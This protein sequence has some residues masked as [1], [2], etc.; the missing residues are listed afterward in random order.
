MSEK[1]DS[2]QIQFPTIHLLVSWTDNPVDDDSWDTSHTLPS[3]GFTDENAITFADDMGVD[4]CCALWLYEGPP[5][6]VGVHERILFNPF[7]SQYVR[8]VRDAKVIPDGPCEMQKM[9]L[10]SEAFARGG[11]T[12]YNDQRDILKNG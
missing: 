5:Y 10:L 9:E 11:M 7:V 1:S 3:Q 4:K 12:A 8:R 2:G 6:V